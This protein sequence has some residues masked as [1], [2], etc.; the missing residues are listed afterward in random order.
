MRMK[1]R[2]LDTMRELFEGNTPMGPTAT[3][4]DIQC[5]LKLTI[6][7]YAM[8]WGDGL[9][10]SGDRIMLKKHLQEAK[11][12]SDPNWEPDASWRWWEPDAPASLTRGKQ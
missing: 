3:E 5:M 7:T 8:G 1:K 11:F 10:A 2:F 4:K 9:E 12:I 6:V